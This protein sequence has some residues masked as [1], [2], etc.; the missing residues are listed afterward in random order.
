MISND[1]CWLSIERNQ[2]MNYEPDAN[3]TINVELY[4]LWC[5]G[6]YSFDKIQS[7]FCQ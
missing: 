1:L 7:G 4:F 2:T 3:D 5:L 6:I